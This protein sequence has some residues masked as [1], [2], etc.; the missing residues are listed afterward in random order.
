MCRTENCETYHKHIKTVP[1]HTLTFLLA[2]LLYAR[3][4][5]MFVNGDN[6]RRLLATLRCFNVTTD[7]TFLASDSWGAKIHPVY[8]QEILAE[9]TVSLLPKRRVI[10]GNGIISRVSSYLYSL[11]HE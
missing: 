6:C 9:G 10:E 11:F 8:G 5:I 7:V 4:V 3:A 2:R 1:I